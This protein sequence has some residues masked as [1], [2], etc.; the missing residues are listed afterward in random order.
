MSVEYIFWNKP[1]KVRDLY[2][3]TDFIIVTRNN[4][5]WIIDSKEFDIEH[6]VTNI[7]ISS[8]SG[9][10]EQIDMDDVIYELENHG[11][12]NVNS[13]MD[14]IVSTFKITFYTDDELENYWQLNHYRQENKPYP[15]PDLLDA[16]GEFDFERAV[17]RSMDNWGDYDVI[18]PK[19]GIVIIPKRDI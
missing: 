6:P 10:P 12:K 1:L 5:E 16:N 3:D 2:D 15:Y 18:N 9:S 17:I 8:R 11:F 14:T 4:H 13:I 7:R 19:E